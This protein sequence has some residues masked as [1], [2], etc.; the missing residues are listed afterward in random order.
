M[1]VALGVARA[2]LGIRLGGDACH[3]FWANV[4]GTSCC[5]IG[6]DLSHGLGT[7]KN[8]LLGTI[9]AEAVVVIV[10]SVIERHF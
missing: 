10:A 3:Q 5:G 8:L 9:T 7:E 1:S 6:E 4:V 2:S